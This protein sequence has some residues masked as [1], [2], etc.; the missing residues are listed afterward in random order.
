MSK[1]PLQAGTVPVRI[2][3]SEENGDFLPCIHELD[4]NSNKHL[5]QKLHKGIDISVEVSTNRRCIGYFESSKELTVCPESRTISSG[6]VCSKCANKDFFR[7]F[8][9]NSRGFS[10][11]AHSFFRDTFI[12]Y[13]VAFGDKPK[14]G[15]CHTDR[16][17]I[18]CIEQGAD[19]CT[20]ICEASDAEEALRIENIIKT[21]T[22]IPDRL[23][24]KSKVENIRMS[25]NK[26]VIKRAKGEVRSKTKFDPEDRDI[27]ELYPHY[28]GG[29]QISERYSLHSGD[30]AIRLNEA[31]DAIKGQLIFTSAKRILN[32]Q[33][34][35]GRT[36]KNPTQ[37][38]LDSF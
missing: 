26:G 35:A 9:T 7:P 16:Y 19:L 2:S 22:T 21:K 32:V 20:I 6:S 15:I 8:V 29:Q 12:V 37:T 11:A 1:K 23:R 18:R 3:W 28:I 27:I 10:T 24:A 25:S 30:R 36:I 17:P 4:I 14:V 31:I 5:K 33:S 38:G 34:I 13:I